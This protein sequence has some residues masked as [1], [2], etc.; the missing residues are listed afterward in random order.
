MGEHALRLAGRRI[1]RR[2]SP[3]LARALRRSDPLRRVGRQC[4]IE[5]AP[6]GRVKPRVLYGN[7]HLPSDG[8]GLFV[9]FFRAE[10]IASGP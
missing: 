2:R 9:S 3:S 6:Q 5:I 1:K 10:S 4:I 7:H 8:I